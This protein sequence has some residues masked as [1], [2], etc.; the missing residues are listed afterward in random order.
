MV[1]LFL[2]WNA[3]SHHGVEMSEARSRVWLRASHGVNIWGGLP[4]PDFVIA[5]P[6][7]LH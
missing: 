6:K 5:Y 1:R 3:C 7:N 2:Q 4:P